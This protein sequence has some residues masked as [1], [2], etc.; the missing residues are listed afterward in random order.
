MKANEAQ[1]LYMD[2]KHVKNTTCIGW[3]ETYWHWKGSVSS[4]WVA[5][6]NRVV[7]SC[8]PSG[9]VDHIRP[10]LDGMLCSSLIGESGEEKKPP[11][12]LEHNSVCSGERTKEAVKEAPSWSSYKGRMDPRTSTSNTN[13]RAGSRGRTNPTTRVCEQKPA[14]SLTLSALW[15]RRH[16]S[17]SSAQRMLSCSPPQCW[18]A[19][20]PHLSLLVSF[21]STTLLLR[22]EHLTA[23][24]RFFPSALLERE[25]LT[26]VSYQCNLHLIVSL[27]N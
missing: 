4:L 1:F 7:W 22:P 14:A 27:L 8:K 25:H 20:I 5:P 2:R 19:F 10:H 23:V 15:C 21:I 26:L 6:L 9:A 11:M 12:T 16:S 17:S 3:T 18:R 24:A 13:R